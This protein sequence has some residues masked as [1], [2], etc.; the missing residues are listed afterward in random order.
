M[1][2]SGCPNGPETEIPYHQ[3]PLNPVPTRQ[4]LLL[5][6][7]QCITWQSLVGIGLMQD[8]VFRLGCLVNKLS[9]LQTTLIYKLQWTSSKRIST[10][11]YD[12]CIL[13]LILT[14][15][16]NFWT[17][18]GSILFVLQNSWHFQTMEEYGRIYF[19]CIFLEFFWNSLGIFNL[20]SQCTAVV[21]LHC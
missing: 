10:S 9:V 16:A 12:I 4:G 17:I 8:W 14:C 5:S 11:K 20:Q 6:P 3:K 15:T 1:Y 18:V 2:W 13:R 19:I 7:W 21:C